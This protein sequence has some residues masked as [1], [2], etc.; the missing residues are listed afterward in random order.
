[1]WRLVR[2]LGI[3]TVLLT[4]SLHA[5]AQMEL[6]TIEHPFHARSLAGI[7]VDPSGGTVPG[8]VIEDC[9][10]T[11]KQVLD[12]TTTDANG[13]FIFPHAKAGT[14]HFLRVSHYGFD[15]MQIT[16]ELGHFAKGGLTIRL[17]IAT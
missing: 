7:V 2:Q 9:D 4:S 15:P 11:F 17:Y 8:V 14:T 12:S 16:V 5:K 1:M 13:H 10:S 3:L 6:I